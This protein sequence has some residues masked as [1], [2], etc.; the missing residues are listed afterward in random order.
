MLY[1]ILYLVLLLLFYLFVFHFVKYKKHGCTFH[2]NSQV[3]NQQGGS[4][5][6]DKIIV[7]EDAPAGVQGAKNAGM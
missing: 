4:I 2:H 1:C 7:F 6:P 5:N 3:F